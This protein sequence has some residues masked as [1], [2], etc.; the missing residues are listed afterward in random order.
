MDKKLIAFRLVTSIFAI[1]VIYLTFVFYPIPKMSGIAGPPSLF[2]YG[3]TILLCIVF[4]IIVGIIYGILRE[5]F[6]KG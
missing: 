6:V 2:S 1:V 4:G 3:Y 5:R